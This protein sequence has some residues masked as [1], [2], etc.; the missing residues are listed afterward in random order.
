MDAH[1]LSRLVADHRLS[2]DEALDVAQDLAYGLA[3]AAY[4]LGDRAR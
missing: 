2:E 1:F 4:R 3:R